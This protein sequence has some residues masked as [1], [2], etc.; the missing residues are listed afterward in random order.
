M[1]IWSTDPTSDFLA[2]YI[3]IVQHNS[4]VSNLYDMN[5]SVISFRSLS[6]TRAKCS[7]FQLRIGCQT[8]S[9]MDLEGKC[10]H[11][12]VDTVAVHVRV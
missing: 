6:H 9:G 2:R 10:K 3:G 11:N 12:S 7:S 5:P 1:Q 4:D 8:K